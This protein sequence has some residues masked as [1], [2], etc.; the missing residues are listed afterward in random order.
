MAFRNEP[1]INV[2]WNP[3]SQFSLL[4]FEKPCS[5]ARFGES[6]ILVVQNL[7]DRERV[8]HLSN[9]HIVRTYSC[10]LVC[11]F[12]SV[13]RYL[14]ASQWTLASREGHRARRETETGN[15]YR[16]IGQLVCFLRVCDDDACCAVG[17]WAAVE[18]FQWC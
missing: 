15:P 3:S 10:H 5:P 17:V 1:S 13:L 11:R 4:F 7:G 6:E 14:E 2:Y 18:E 9:I 16:S 12:S 8:V